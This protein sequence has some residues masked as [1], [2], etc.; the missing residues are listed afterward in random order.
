MDPRP[1]I[2]YFPILTTILTIVFAAQI[3]RRYVQR[4]RI[5]N[6][7]LWWTIGVLTYGLGTFTESYI[8]IL[9]WNPVIFKV[10]Y[11]AGA[12][13]GGAPLA[14][15][16]VW[17]LLKSQTAKRLTFALLTAVVV[18]AIFIIVSPVN[19]PVDPHLPSGRALGWQWVRFFSP[20]INTYAVVF[21][22]GGAILS[23]VR[24]RRVATEGQGDVA[25][26]AQDR[27]FG[28]VLIAAGAILPA[29]GGASSRAGHTQV[30]YILELAGIILIWLGYWFNVRKRPLDE[31]L[32]DTAA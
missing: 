32:P 21:L 16:T 13:L 10:W 22:I 27:F 1:F 3:Y 23:A 17:L 14:Q 31:P 25:E 30:L 26:L 5:G 9:G 28:N 7:L 24:Y 20:F 18:S 4:G 8:T 29:I 6:H 19:A 2:Y 12:L 15:G 11:I